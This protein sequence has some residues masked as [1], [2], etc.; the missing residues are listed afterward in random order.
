[1]SRGKSSISKPLSYYDLLDHLQNSKGCALCKIELDAVSRYIDTVLTEMVND[2]AT[3]QQLSHHGYCP[4]HAH[5]LA[6]RGHPL[7][8]ALLYTDQLK[9]V[10]GMLA[11]PELFVR[12]FRGRLLAHQGDKATCPA[13]Q[14]QFECRSRVVKSLFELL[15]DEEVRDAFAHSA[16]LCMPHLAVSVH[17]A[18]D[19]ALRQTLIETQIRTTTNLIEQL[20]EFCRKHDYR[21]QH[22]RF[23]EESDS[24]IRAIE[25][26]VGSKGVF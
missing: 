11:E 25:M 4:R 3:R 18:S 15:A 20:R 21:F 14:V 5:I 19:P 8:K 2:P 22:E 1:M 17:S 12:T 16:G 7:A 23:A 10:V 13:C 26:M 9:T 6:T 24:W